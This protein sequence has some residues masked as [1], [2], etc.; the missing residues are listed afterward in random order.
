M[1]G[2]RGSQLRRGGNQRRATSSRLRRLI[3]TMIFAIVGGGLAL[4]ITSMEANSIEKATIKAEEKHLMHEME[5]N[6]IE[7]KNFDFEK[8]DPRNPSNPFQDQQEQLENIQPIDV[9]QIESESASDSKDTVVEESN[10]SNIEGSETEV[11]LEAEVEAEVE[12]IVEEKK[13][14]KKASSSK[15]P[16]RIALLGERNTGT[17][18]MTSELQKCFPTLKVTSRLLRWKH[19]FQ[20]DDEKSHYPTLVIAQFRNIYEWTEAMRNVPH[21]APEHLHLEWKEFVTKPWTMERPKRDEI[22]KDSNEKVCYEK[23]RYNE[24]ISCIE[25][26]REDPDYL[27]WA[28]KTGYKAKHDFS[29]HKPIY[30]LKQDGSGEPFSSI[31]EMRAAKIRNFLS[32]KEWKWISNSIPVQY[33]KLLSD[34]TDFLLTQIEEELGIKRQCK[35]VPPQNRKKRQL[36][37]D[38]VK[39]M[40]ENVDWESEGL[41]EYE[42]WPDPGDAE[43]SEDESEDEEDMED[44]ASDGDDEEDEEEEEEEEEEEKGLETE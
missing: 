5:N 17:R 9:P 42:P 2:T 19:W 37:P 27:E 34:G 4:F 7:P 44:L 23:F 26:S 24:L 1:R 6:K 29:G 43:E 12:D 18:W 32:L 10:I 30:E 20:E 13:T 41:I 31:L 3:V 25:G 21:H 15:L 39:W 38:Y 16:R 33:E 8:E 14:E 11:E 28:K 36:P 40:T 35:A 22:H